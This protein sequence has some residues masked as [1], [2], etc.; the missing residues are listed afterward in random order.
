MAPGA[1]EVTHPWRTASD[2]VQLAALREALIA[3]AGNITNA[4][5]RLGVHR[6]HAMRLLKKH[7]LVQFAAELRQRAGNRTRGRQ[8]HRKPPPSR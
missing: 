7:D 2:E 4:A 5:A 3:E 8:W 6:T 1:W